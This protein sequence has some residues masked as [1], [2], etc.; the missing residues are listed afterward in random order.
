MSCG[1]KDPFVDD[2]VIFAGRVRESKRMRKQ[3]LEASRRRNGKVYDGL[4]MTGRESKETER[5][6]DETEEDWVRMAIIEGW[7]HGFL[8]MSTMMPEAREAIYRIGEWINDAFASHEPRA[9]ATHGARQQNGCDVSVIGSSETETDDTEGLMFVPRK[10]RTPPSS[11]GKG[12]DEQGTEADHNR[13]SDET[14]IGGGMTATTTTTTSARA[15][16]RDKWHPGHRVG[17]PASG[18]PLVTDML[19]ASPVIAAT[20]GTAMHEQQRGASPSAG[21]AALVPEGDLLKRR[22]EEAV[23]GIGDVRAVEYPTGR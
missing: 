8:Q 7:S 15:M 22:R 16:A 9:C 18:K 13:S 20:I 3:E 12:C 11:I 19:V 21:K 10:K 4:H 23:F 17:S 14:L 5:I 6:L 1:E 2:T